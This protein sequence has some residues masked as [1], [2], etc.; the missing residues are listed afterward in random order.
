V[1]PAR[2][3]AV[4]SNPVARS[5]E[6]SDSIK[7]SRSTTP[8]RSR[9]ATPESVAADLSRVFDYIPNFFVV[10]RCVRKE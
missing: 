1:I 3:P 6:I 8:Q 10:V 5:P 7:S 9:H 4:A 2:R